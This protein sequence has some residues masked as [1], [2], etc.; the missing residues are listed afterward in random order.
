MKDSSFTFTQQSGR[1]THLVHCDEKTV[2]IGTSGSVFLHQAL[3]LVESDILTVSN[4]TAG[5]IKDQ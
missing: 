4:Y 3:N 5:Q 1:F 2:A